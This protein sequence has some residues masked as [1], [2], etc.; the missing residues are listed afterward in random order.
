MDVRDYSRLGFV[1]SGAHGWHHWPKHGDVVARSVNNYH[2]E[3][4]TNKVLLILKIAVNR[5]K[6][7]KLRRSQLQQFAVFHPR[8]PRFCNGRYLVARKLLTKGARDA[9]VKQHAHLRSNGPS[10]ARAQQQRF[11]D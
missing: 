3:Q 7:V 4:K 1:D 11:P 10:P 5:Q 2:R 8:P 6:E 9:F